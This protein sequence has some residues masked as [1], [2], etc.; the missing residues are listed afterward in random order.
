MRVGFS[1]FESHLQKVLI[2]WVLLGQVGGM[3]SLTSAPSIM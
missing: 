3:C 2:D 1:G